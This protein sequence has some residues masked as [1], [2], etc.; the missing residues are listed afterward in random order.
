MTFVSFLKVL[1]KVFL[2]L[3]LSFFFALLISIPLYFI[4]NSFPVFFTASALVLILAALI[5]LILSSIK[6]YGIFSFFRVF[7]PL[8][9]TSSG[10]IF[11]IRLLFLEIYGRRIFSLLILLITAGI[12]ILLYFIFK[13]AKQ[14]K[15]ENQK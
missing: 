11:S 13:K 10:I 4:S 14:A 6:K 5:Y 3:L 9:F 12:N 7:L 2:L 15:N 1:L 8:S